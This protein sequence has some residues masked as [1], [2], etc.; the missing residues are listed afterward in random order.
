MAEERRYDISAFVLHLL[1]MGLMLCDHLWATVLSW[2]ILTWLGRMAFP[3]FA[4]MLVEGYVHT[5][6][7][8]KYALRLLI[9]A[10]IS[11]IPFNL[12]CSGGWIYPY[13]QNV[14]WTLL[15]SLLCIHVI[16]RVRRVGKLWLTLLI[17]AAVSLV[18][19]LLG[20]LTMIDYYGY[21]VLT[22]LIFYLFRGRRWY[23]LIGQILLLG[24]INLEMMGG[25]VI[26][27]ELF[28]RSFHVAQQGMALLALIP[29]WL[30]RG[31]QGL[32][33]RVIRYS[34]YAFYPLHMLLLVLLQIL[35]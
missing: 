17:A 13:H 28:G 35:F 23:C 24:Y 7:V 14:L 34:F 25:L 11:E 12:L 32:H 20:F 30:Y 2:D 10:L 8:K 3:L 9:F 15:L 33:S 5:R 26:P 31:R 22:V 27:V 19:F 6:S 1:A 4:F 18:G 29:I 16:E 21:G